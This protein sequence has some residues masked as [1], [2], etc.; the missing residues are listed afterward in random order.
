MEYKSFFEEDKN[1]FH[2]QSN[3]Y[4]SQCNA[5]KDLSLHELLKITSD[6]AVEDY[7]QRGMSRKILKDNGFGILVSRCSYRIHKWPK[8]NQFIEVETWEEKP[9]T[10][11][12]MRGY[13]ILDE[14]K[15]ILVSGKSSWLL[16]DINERRI[17]PLKKFTLRTPSEFCIDLDC[18]KPDKILQPEKSELWDTRIIKFSDLDANGHTNNARYAAFIEDAIPEEFRGRKP[19]DFKINF[20]KEAML[21]DKVEIFGFKEEN[22]ITFL[23]KTPESVSFEAVI[24]Y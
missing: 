9:Q 14:N 20:A 10:L 15:N 23:G 4:F 7:R 11:Q 21:N 2:V 13:K 6:I 8:E 12:F 19:K 3:I 16:V 18:D 5:N 24:S 22:K 1:I 17:L